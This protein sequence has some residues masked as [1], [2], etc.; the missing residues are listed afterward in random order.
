RKAKKTLTGDAVATLA[1]S[2]FPARFRDDLSAR[3]M[4]PAQPSPAAPTP[5]LPGYRATFGADRPMRL[6]CGAELGPFTIAWQ[7]DG[8]LDSARSTASLACHALTGDQCLAEAHP[9]TGKPGWWSERVGP[10]LPLDTNRY[11][12]ICANV[13]GGCMGTTG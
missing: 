10:G 4:T 8:Q 5:V 3:Y 9:I 1:K 6:D 2:L 11:F 13:L 12:V 7:T